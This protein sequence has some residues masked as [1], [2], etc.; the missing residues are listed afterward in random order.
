MQTLTRTNHFAW[1]LLVLPAF[2]GAHVMGLLDG[3][4][5][6]PSETLEVEDANKKRVVVEN[7]T[8]VLWITR[9]QRVLCFLLNSW[10]PDILSHVLDV[11]SSAEA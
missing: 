10:S 7:P 5:H 9:D 1:K 3:T 11:S 4:D 2:R 8:Y 6:A